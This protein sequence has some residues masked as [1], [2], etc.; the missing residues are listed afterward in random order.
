MSR[1]LLALALLVLVPASLRAQQDDAWFGRTAKEFARYMA[2]DHPVERQKALDLLAGTT[3]PDAAPLLI[4]WIDK[5]SAEERHYKALADKA[6]QKLDAEYEKKVVKPR[7]S[8][9]KRQEARELFERLTEG[10]R[11][12]I[13]EWRLRENDDR[14]QLIHM[15]VLLRDLFERIEGEALEKASRSVVK[16]LEQQRSPEAQADLIS[17]MGFAPSPLVEAELIRLARTSPYPSVRVC[18][19]DALARH[20]TEASAQAGAALLADEFDQVRFAAILM[21][22]KVGGKEAVI[23]LIDR[24]EPEN[25]RL[26]DE[27]VKTLVELTGGSFGDNPRAWRD[28]WQ[29]YGATFEGRGPSARVTGWID[30]QKAD[31]AAKDGPGRGGASRPQGGES[32]FYGIKTRATRILFILDV[33]G[34]MEEEVVD[35][36]TKHAQAIAELKRAIGNLPAA[37]AFNVI[38]YNEDVSVWKDQMQKATDANKKAAYA[39]VDA[40]KAAGATNIFDALEKG[41][42]MAGRGTFDKHYEVGIETI[43]LLSDGTP[44]RGRLIDPRDILEEVDRLNALSKIQIHTIA[45]GSAGPGALMQQLAKRNNGEYALVR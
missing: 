23:A 12:M 7:M 16:N 35:G 14:S 27:I 37:G 22:R 2:S 19:L 40:T 21:L 25:D 44:T 33:S 10:E 3:H 5:M 13:A 26:A 30:K 41:F 8:D 45:L 34:S 15:K 43:F 32:T 24:L 1:P 9:G 28:W 20:E 39:W 42:T 4:E 36:G 18:V 6:Q 31:R 11:A 17:A 38:F 29:E